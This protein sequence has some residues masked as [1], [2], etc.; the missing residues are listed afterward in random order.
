[1]STSNVGDH[2]LLATISAVSVVSITVFTG[3]ID[4]SVL[5]C[6]ISVAYSIVNTIPQSKPLA[7]L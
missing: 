5:F 3:C 2:V 7:E 4:G 6:G 1:M